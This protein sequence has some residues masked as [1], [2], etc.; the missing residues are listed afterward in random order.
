MQSPNDVLD[1]WLNQVGPDRWYAPDP[2]LDHLIREK[3]LSTWEQA[4][5]GS[6]T[7][8]WAMRP[9]STLALLIVLDQF[10]RNMFRGT[11]KA[12]S[13]D[14]KARMVAKKAIERKW[15]LRIAEP[16]RQF[17]YLPLMHSEC[18]SDQERCVRLMLT[19]MPDS[20]EEYLIH[21]KAHREVIRW[22]GR[23]PFRNEA[24]DRSYTAPEIEFIK[25]GG[26]S[27][28]FRAVSG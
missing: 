23:F 16:E 4:N 7:T 2:K 9:E 17:F 20:G 10:P 26:Y 19:R 6:L 25:E 18:I 22:F 5:S 27:V 24:L 15:D 1:F 14:S 21:A 3:F 8:E 12:F 11:G 28:A 13:T